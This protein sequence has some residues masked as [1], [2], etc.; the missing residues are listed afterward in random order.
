[1]TGDRRVPPRRI[2]SPTITE[3]LAAFLDEQ[4]SRLRPATTRQYESAIS[5]FKASMGGR[6]VLGDVTVSGNEVSVETKTT[7]WAGRF[8]QLLDEK[9]GPGVELFSVT[10]RD[11]NAFPRE[12]G[13][14]KRR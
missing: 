10:Y 2:A 12:A 3:V 9:V 1:M 4:R 6:Q 13:R 11:V 5:L 7:S 8:A 14:G